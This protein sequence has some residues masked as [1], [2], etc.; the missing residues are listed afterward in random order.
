MRTLS[1]FVAKTKAMKLKTLAFSFMLTLFPPFLCNGERTES[2]ILYLSGDPDPT[3]VDPGPTKKRSKGKQ[4]PCEITIDGISISGVDTSGINL[5]EVL[6]IDGITLASFE[7]EQEFLTYLFTLEETVGIRLYFDGF[8]LSGFQI[9]IILTLHNHP[10]KSTHHEIF[11]SD[12]HNS[13]FSWI[14]RRIL[15][16]S[17]D[18]EHCRGMA[19]Q[20]NCFA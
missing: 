8:V 20:T 7:T 12:I 1:N 2:F 4:L 14:L 13:T 9:Q 10:K 5:Y 11:V 15:R 3:E 19:R 17:T 16:Q 6:D 18:S